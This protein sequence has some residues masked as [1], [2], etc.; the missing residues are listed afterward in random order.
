MKNLVIA[1][2][3]LVSALSSCKSTN[4]NKVFATLNPSST[5]YKQELVKQFLDKGTENLKFTFKGLLSIT[6][7][8]YMQ[9]DINGSGIQAQTMILISNW[10]KLEGIKRTKGKSYH[11]AELAHL[12]LDIV[13]NN[14]GPT[15]VYRD[16]EKI[17]D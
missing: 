16:L 2:I 4:T 9:V 11:G 13:T 17:V 8:D 6:G 3:V 12:Q 1:T 5:Q 10:K 7:K 15:F 14:S